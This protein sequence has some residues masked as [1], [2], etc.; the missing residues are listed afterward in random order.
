MVLPISNIT[1]KCI[2]VKDDPSPSFYLSILYVA[3]YFQCSY[4]HE[5]VPED[6][7]HLSYFGS[8]LTIDGGCGT[9]IRK[10]LKNLASTLTNRRN[11]LDTRKRIL[12]SDVWSVLKYS[13]DKIFRVM[14][15]QAYAKTIMVSWRNTQKFD[16][17]D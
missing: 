11:K 10:L 8:I 6:Q 14:A 16:E 9:K 4:Y 12:N 7:M 17:R 1:A 2:F 3:F 13:C 5:Y 15:F